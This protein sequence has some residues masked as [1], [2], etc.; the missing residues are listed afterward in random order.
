MHRQAGRSRQLFGGLIV[1]V[2]MAATLAC[3]GG[4]GTKEETYTP[5]NPEVPAAFRAPSPTP[6]TVLAAVPSPTP[7]PPSAGNPPTAEGLRSAAF[8]MA[9]LVLDVP[10]GGDARPAYRLLSQECRNRKSY[11]EFVAELQRSPEEF[12]KQWG[13]DQ[14]T[15]RVKDVRVSNVDGKKG[16]ATI[17]FSSTRNGSIAIKVTQALGAVPAIYENGD[18]RFGSNR[19]WVCA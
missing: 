12:L 9:K 8:E 18:W 16:E 11:E 13:V 3:G 14:N 1:G 6:T 5:K 4:G 19:S 15:F 2:L 7:L 10:T 17:E